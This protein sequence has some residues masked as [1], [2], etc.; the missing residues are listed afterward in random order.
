MVNSTVLT[1]LL[2]VLETNNIITFTKKK[3]WGFV[4]VYKYFKYFKIQIS[5]F[6]LKKKIK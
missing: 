6:K 3:L 2:C 4:C 5:C 1:A